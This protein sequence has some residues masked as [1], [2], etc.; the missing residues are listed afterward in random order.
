MPKIDL[1]NKEAD[2]DQILSDIYDGSFRFR[3]KLYA[4][5]TVKCVAEGA[6]LGAV[7]ALALVG[8]LAIVADALTPLTE[9]SE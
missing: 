4:K 8:V 3:T 1:F 9:E 6:I 5:Y 7:A 2:Y